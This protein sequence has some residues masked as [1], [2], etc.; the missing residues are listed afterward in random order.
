MFE[1]LSG[2]SFRRFL[3]GEI[4]VMSVNRQKKPP[5]V[6]EAAVRGGGGGCYNITTMG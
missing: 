4:S 2:P 5:I 1:F 3:L 6:I